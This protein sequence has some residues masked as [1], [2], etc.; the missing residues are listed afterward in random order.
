MT[1]QPFCEGAYYFSASPDQL[2]S[3]ASTSLSS[4]ECCL[5]GEGLRPP[6]WLRSKRAECQPVAFLS[7]REDAQH[8]SKI[9]GLCRSSGRHCLLLNLI[10]DSCD[11]LRGQLPGSDLSWPRILIQALSPPLTPP[12]LMPFCTSL[13][14]CV[15]HNTSALYSRMS[16]SDDPVGGFT[17]WGTGSASEHKAESSGSWNP[18]CFNMHFHLAPK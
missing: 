9:P 14:H 10:I 7:P 2:W 5:L 6:L 15:V 1:G 17:N 13:I 8:R 12:L 16:G 4:L 3:N 18:A 11:Y